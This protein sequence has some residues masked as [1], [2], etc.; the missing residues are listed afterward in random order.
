MQ[1]VHVNVTLGHGVTL[2]HYRQ[3]TDE[4]TCSALEELPPI[5]QNLFYDFDY[6]QYTVLPRPIKVLPVGSSF[7]AL[8]MHIPSLFINV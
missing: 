6:Q 7:S 2:R 4:S 1:Y 8:C 5:E 3:T